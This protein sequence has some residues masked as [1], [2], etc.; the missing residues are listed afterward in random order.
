MNRAH[1]DI[2][3]I[4]FVTH[5]IA[6]AVFMASRI[7]II[8]S[9]PGRIKHVIPNPLPY[10]RDVNSAGFAAL[11]DQIHAAITA[12]ALPDEPGEAA[13]RRAAATVPPE[14]PGAPAAGVAAQQRTR[15][16]SVPAVQV[17]TI[18][19]LLRVL[20]DSQEII[21]VFELSAKIGKEFGETIAIVKA[22]EML[23]L[24]DTP[25]DDVQMT[26]VGWYFLAAPLPARKA[27]FRQAI[28]KLRLF[29]IVSAHL[30][31]SD[32]G[33][34]RRRRHCERSSRRCCPTI[35]RRNFSRR[36]SRGAA[37][38]RSS[39]T[40]RMPIAS[41]ASNRIAESDDDDGAGSERERGMNA[42][43]EI[44]TA[45]DVALD[46]EVADRDGLLGFAAALIARRHGLQAAEIGRQLAVREGLGSTA[47]GHGVA[48]PHARIAGLRRS[49][50]AL[51]RTKQ[52]IP[53]AA[54]DGRSVASFL[55]LLVPAQAADQ[56]LK[57]IA[58][59][60]GLFSDPAFRANLH[61]AATADEVARLFAE[62][63]PG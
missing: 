7:V 34:D 12:V 59:A 27:L 25:K 1:A 56:H 57:L 4:F 39:T 58:E 52:P 40:T 55:V 31:E 32:R 37:T 23:G 42:L 36:W 38:R 63:P 3:S 43:G 50:A 26:Q 62:W 5:N 28:M 9:H 35:S 16:E 10:P 11:V 61:S 19:G 22:A 53:F 47:L 21:D 24:V 30:D 44:L 2:K 51:V 18:V 41:R 48:L 33:H 14:V 17:G 60:A 29:Q 20:E 13:H 54:A 46:V 45:A 49:I 15:V 6:E 8:S